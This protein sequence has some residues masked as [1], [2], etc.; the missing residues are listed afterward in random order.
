MWFPAVGRERVKENLREDPAM[1]SMLMEA[2]VISFA[3]GGVVG[4]VVTM[5]LVHPKKAEATKTSKQ[6]S[7]EALEP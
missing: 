3:L 1:M 7:K 2:V 5:H 4:A 6:V